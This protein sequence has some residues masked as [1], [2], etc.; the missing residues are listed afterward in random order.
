MAKK[1]LWFFLFSCFMKNMK[2]IKDSQI[3]LD[4][5]MNVAISLN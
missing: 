5:K 2:Y 4:L 1:N 3:Y